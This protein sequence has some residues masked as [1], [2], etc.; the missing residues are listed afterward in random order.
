MEKRKY[1]DFFE[2]EEFINYVNELY[3][4][5]KVPTYDNLIKQ[6]VKAEKERNSAFKKFSDEQTKNL[7]RAISLWLK[8]FH[9]HYFE[10]EYRKNRKERYDFILNSIKISQIKPSQDIM[11]LINKEISDKGRAK[12]NARENH[13]YPK[14]WEIELSKKN[15]GINDSEVIKNLYITPPEGSI[16]F[17]LENKKK[18]INNETLIQYLY[19]HKKFEI[20][21]KCRAK[22]IF[23]EVHKEIIKKIKEDFSGRYKYIKTTLKNYILKK[24]DE[25]YSELINITKFNFSNSEVVLFL[26][27]P[28]LY[29]EIF[30]KESREILTELFEYPEIQAIYFDSPELEVI[31]NCFSEMAASAVEYNIIIPELKKE[32]WKIILSKLDGKEIFVEIIKKMSE[33]L[34]STHPKFLEKLSMYV[35]D[36]LETLSTRYEIPQLQ[37]KLEF[38][39]G[40]DEDKEKIAVEFEFSDEEKKFIW[41][42]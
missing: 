19:K 24:P 5:K 35:K 25:M 10:I 21:R 39:L 15:T 30:G 18:S 11:V 33:A 6:Y 20:E 7:I 42:E 13:E 8:Y 29:E 36:V 4:D 22:L 3:S 28:P 16:E 26:M 1:D 17:I 14:E 23:Y 41:T 34:K 38:A 12:Q 32:E 40:D 2:S 31:V 9:E 37:G 27:N